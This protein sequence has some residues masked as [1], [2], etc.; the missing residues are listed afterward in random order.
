LWRELLRRIGFDPRISLVDSFSV[1][2]MR[3]I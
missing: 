1:S 3:V 2:G